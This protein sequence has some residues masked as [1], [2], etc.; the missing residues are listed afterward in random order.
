M[1]YF[2]FSRGWAYSTQANDLQ[3]LGELYQALDQLQDAEK[4]FQSALNIS[5][6]IGENLGQGNALYE[7]G[8]LCTTQHRFSEAQDFLTRAKDVYGRAH[9]PRW[10]KYTQDLLEDLHNK[11]DEQQ[12]L[13]EEE[14]S[15][16]GEN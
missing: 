11:R 3:A 2:R 6:E 10:Q 1:K 9:H 5:T 14:A 15:G 16:D 7:L 13:V 8:K 4:A 12:D